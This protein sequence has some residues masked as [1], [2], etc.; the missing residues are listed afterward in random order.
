MLLATCFIFQL[1]ISTHCNIN[2]QVLNLS[3]NLKR[4]LV[5]RQACPD[6]SMCLSQ[7][8]YCGTTDEY[9]GTGC[10]GGP[11]KGNGGGNNGG[12]NGGNDGGII[13]DSNFGCV[14]NTLD[15]STRGQRLDGLRR[16]GYKPG[17]ADEAAVFLAHVFHET[18][19][20]RTLTEYCA[21]GKSHFVYS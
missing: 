3:S 11:C 18:D 4:L 7:W 17:N 13:T 20:L 10:K 2:D 5:R 16:S 14:F 9:C 12:N 1:I 15:G 6:A 8:G 19:G 21:P